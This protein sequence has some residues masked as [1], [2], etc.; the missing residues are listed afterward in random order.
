MCGCAI[1]CVR[2]RKCVYQ[3]EFHSQKV[4]IQNELWISYLSKT[5]L[6]N[7]NVFKYAWANVLFFTDKHWNVLTTHLKWMSNNEPGEPQPEMNY[8]NLA[9]SSQNI[10][11]QGEKH[12]NELEVFWVIEDNW[13]KNDHG[14]IEQIKTYWRSGS[15]AR[16]NL[17]YLEKIRGRG[18]SVSV[19]LSFSC[20]ISLLAVFV[21]VSLLSLIPFVSLSLC[22]SPLPLFFCSSVW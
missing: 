3:V 13:W 18:L 8:S 17:D 6:P 2:K 1:V 15:K 12:L 11:H 20:F 19:A 10:V 22:S 14:H 7:P 5:H 16:P 4:Y 21:S 9:N